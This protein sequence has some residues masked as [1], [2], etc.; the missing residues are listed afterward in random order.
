MKTFKLLSL[1]LIAVMTNLGCGEPDKFNDR[2]FAGS[3]SNNPEAAVVEELSLQNSSGDNGLLTPTSKDPNIF[4][5]QIVPR[6]SDAWRAPKGL[7]YRR[8]VNWMNVRSADGYSDSQNYSACAEAIYNGDKD[9]QLKGKLIAYVERIEVHAAKN[10][11]LERS[12]EG[13]NHLRYDWPQN[14][15]RS[16]RYVGRCSYLFFSTMVAEHLSITG[17]YPKSNPLWTAD[18][19]CLTCPP[20]VFSSGPVQPFRSHSDQEW[21]QFRKR[22][23]SALDFIKRSIHSYSFSSREISVTFSTRNAPLY[24]EKISKIYNRFGNDPKN[25]ASDWLTILEPTEYRPIV[26]LPGFECAES[27]YIHFP[28]A[29][30]RNSTSKRFG[31]RP[32]IEILG[33]C[34]DYNFGKQI[35]L[36]NGLKCIDVTTNPLIDLKSISSDSSGKVHHSEFSCEKSF[37]V[38]NGVMR[39]SSCVAVLEHCRK[40]PSEPLVQELASFDANLT[41]Q[42]C[43]DLTKRKTDACASYSPG[44]TYMKPETWMY[45][46]SEKTTT[47]AFNGCAVTVDSCRKDPKLNGIEQRFYQS[48]A[49]ESQCMLA[50]RDFVINQCGNLPGERHP[51][52]RYLKYDRQYSLQKE[53]YRPEIVVNQQIAIGN[54]KTLEQSSQDIEIEVSY[55][56]DDLMGQVPSS[57]LENQESKWTLTAMG[58]SKL[59]VKL[60]QNS[61]LSPIKFITAP[62]KNGFKLRL[63]VSLQA[64]SNRGNFDLGLKISTWFGLSF[65]PTKIEKEFRVTGMIVPANPAWQN[66]ANRFDVNADGHVNSQDALVIIN[67]LRRSGPRELDDVGPIEATKRYFDV[68]G[69]GYLNATDSL[70]VINRIKGE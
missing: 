44:L 23:T 34:S 70:A 68:N 40:N 21:L 38:I 63:T 24:G 42:Q 17:D 9:P 59:G 54:I 2:K 45:F 69:D 67:E 66:P 20:I 41:P 64:G 51:R 10:W 6:S 52:I 39:S 7:T 22:T 53:S 43:L 50:A 4:D 26:S 36:A 30:V 14:G 8:V 12:A 11:M 35:D 27:P 31:D 65:N 46:G 28:V 19:R 29:R 1:G 13:Y 33:A 61:N 58:E 25:K 55:P 48:S 15:M 37:P 62:S 3:E 57:M 49:D 32:Y 16:L 56:K 60:V 5:V 18:K 47:E